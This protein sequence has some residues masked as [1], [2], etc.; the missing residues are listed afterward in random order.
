MNKTKAKELT[1]SIIVNTEE[2]DLIKNSLVCYRLYSLEAA[3][4]NKM[5]SLIAESERWEVI[6]AKKLSSKLEEI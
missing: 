4:A 3:R 5:N 1:H 2:L 6:K